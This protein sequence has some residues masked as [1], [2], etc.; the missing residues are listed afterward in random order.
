[1]ARTISIPEDVLTSIKEIRR[2]GG[3]PSDTATL[4]GIV[5]MASPGI[6]AHY[7]G[8]QYRPDTNPVPSQ[9]VPDTNHVLEVSTYPV[10]SQYEPSTD[11]VPP[12]GTN[13][14]RTTYQPSTDED[15]PT[16]AAMA[17]IDFDA[18]I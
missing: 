5:R 18:D 10:P 3:Y 12:T 1:M 7:S 8:Y 4:W 6:I 15:D 11:H 14:V 9:Y 13:P 17:A 16:L 2:L